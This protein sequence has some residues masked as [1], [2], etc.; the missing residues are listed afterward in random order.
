MGTGNTVKL[1]FTGDSTDLD[2]TVDKVGKSGEGL[3]SKLKGAG[4][5]VAGIG[6]V[7]GG[8]YMA[9]FATSLDFGASQAKLQ[10]QLGTGTPLA[11]NAGKAAGDVYASGFGD[12]LDTVNEAMRTVITQGVV[13]KDAT[14]DQMSAITKSA[15]TVA[16]T[17][18][19]DVNDAVS[20]VGQLMKTGLAPDAQS[21]FDLI[22][23]AEQ[24]GVD[25]AGDLLDTITEYSTQFRK[26]GLDGPTA[27]GLLSQGLQ[28]GARDADTVADAIKEFSIRAID[29]SQTSAAAFQGLGLNAKAMTEQI[30]KGGPA[31]EQGLGTV[32]D[33]LRA[34]KDPATQAQL[35][36]GL[37]GTKAEDLGQAL[38]AL[39]P[40]KAAQALGTVAGATNQLGD[41]VNNTAQNKIETIKRGFE[42]W[43]NSMVQTQGPIGD[44]S[45]VLVA[46]GGP[47]GQAATALG[48]LTPVLITMGT[49]LF[50]VVIPAVWSF[51]AALLANPITWVVIAV[52]ALIAV[53][54]LMI[55]H[56]DDVKRVAGDVFGWIGDRLSWVGQRFADVGN[57][58]RDRWN[59]AFAAVKTTISNV[60]DWFGS[61]VDWI[62]GLFG[63]IGDGIKGAFRSAFNFV[64]D[65]WNNTVGRISINIPS[66]VPII[67][68]NS[69]SAP[70]IPKY[71][72][73]IDRVPGA[74]GS[75]M[76][77]VLQAGEQVIPA[78]AAGRGGGSTVVI[79]ADGS[80]T[81]QLLL[82]LLR[83]AIYNE[84]GDV[85]EV[86]S[87]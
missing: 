68:G 44:L 3:K 60:W 81:S 32:L 72:T 65:I 76:L 15:L 24:Q 30:A 77:A 23:R 11:Q 22:S 42:T 73:G 38:Y 86:L 57:W 33:R 51:T 61:K 34:V 67:G 83:Q 69:F 12:S 66:W 84:G 14:T 6:A 43:T 50:T 21:A 62:S 5:A 4:A 1:V 85:Q 70:K 39:D 8:A 55:T 9:A 74:P 31:A 46:F 7:A 52:V 54:V 41:A 10:G 28:A 63:R 19:L 18:G 78:G 80:A 58:F 45:G 59:D 47:I 17:F 71:H 25:K 37:F 35:A 82:Q 16:D 2:K 29:G 53:I 79:R 64:A 48:L 49:T 87:R 40:S 75:E 26:L 36:V 13:M 27:M 56:L 20:A